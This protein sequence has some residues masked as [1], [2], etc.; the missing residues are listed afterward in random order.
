[1]SEPANFDPTPADLLVMKGASLFSKGQYPQ[2]E[3]I[4]LQALREDPAHAGAN[5]FL[6]GVERERGDYEKAL[7]YIESAVAKFPSAAYLMS[8][9]ELKIVLGRRP[10][11]IEDLKLCI[12]SDRRG[13]FLEKAASLL[14]MNYMEDGDF[15]EAMKY[16]DEVIKI[17]PTHA[18]ALKLRSACKLKLGDEDGAKDDEARACESGFD[19]DNPLAGITK[20]GPNAVPEGTVT[21]SRPDDSDANPWVGAAYMDKQGTLRFSYIQHFGSAVIYGFADVT[22][23]ARGFYNGLLRRLRINRGFYAE[24]LGVL[25]IAP[26]EVIVLSDKSNS[27]IPLDIRGLVFGMFYPDKNQSAVAQN[28]ELRYQLAGKVKEAKIQNNLVELH[29]H[30]LTGYLVDHSKNISSNAEFREAYRQDCARMSQSVRE[31]L[32][33]YT[34]ERPYVEKDVFAAVYVLDPTV[35]VEDEEKSLLCEHFPESIRV[36]KKL[37]KEQ[38]S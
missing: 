15:V 24:M 13:Q 21:S 27:K 35:K 25:G 37:L 2:A 30:R 17:D 12:E 32:S 18:A 4:L 31:R 29:T 22:A 38:L 23:D 1:M 3:E 14:A 26:G 16:L 10:E 6:S 20:P 7:A 19:S 34:Q 11:S 8:R 33:L 9:A 28:A 5:A 36:A